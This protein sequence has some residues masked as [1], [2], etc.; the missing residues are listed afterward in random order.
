MCAGKRA[1]ERGSNNHH[2]F[3]ISVGEVS[4]A[5]FNKLHHCLQYRNLLEPFNGF[6]VC[7]VTACTIMESLFLCGTMMI[8]K[9]IFLHD[10]VCS[11]WTVCSVCNKD[12][13]WVLSL[14]MGNGDSHVDTQ[15][16]GLTSGWKL[17]HMQCPA[18]FDDRLPLP[19]AYDR[20]SRGSSFSPLVSSFSSSGNYDQ[21]PSQ[22]HSRL[23]VEVL[24]SL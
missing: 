15:L 13:Q 1:S 12:S 16:P 3:I 11:V 19:I 20:A 14:W 6:A 4:P 24:S 5:H 18:R 2:W 22:I 10:V 21:Q 7:C 8:Q 17:Q 9:L 23:S